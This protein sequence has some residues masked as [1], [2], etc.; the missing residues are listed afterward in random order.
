MLHINMVSGGWVVDYLMD[1]D[2]A[3]AFDRLG[4]RTGWHVVNVLL[5]I[6][7]TQLVYIY[8]YFIHTLNYIMVIEKNRN[9]AAHNVDIIH[10]QI[11]YSWLLL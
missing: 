5:H 11:H 9:T 2:Q 8:T 10:L 4:V 3:A 1:A 6:F 7:L